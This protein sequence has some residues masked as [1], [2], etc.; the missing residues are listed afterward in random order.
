MSLPRCLDYVARRST[1]TLTAGDD[2]RAGCSRNPPRTSPGARLLTESPRTAP[3]H[4]EAYEGLL[5]PARLQRIRVPLLTSHG[6]FELLAARLGV[7]VARSVADECHRISGGSP[8]LVQALAD[9]QLAEG[10]ARDDRPVLGEAFRDAVLSCLYRCE[11][12]LLR[13]ARALAVSG[14][15]LRGGLSARLVEGHGAAVL[16]SIDV[17]TSGGLVVD[18]RLRHPAVGQA[19]LDGM[20]AE[21]RVRLHRQ[22][23]GLLH[24]D[25]APAGEVARH[26]VQAGTPVE[27]WMTQALVEGGE[28]ALRDGDVHTSLRYLRQANRECPDDGARTRVR[29]ALVRAEWQLD[30]Q[31]V[32]PHLPGLVDAVRSGHLGAHQ[33]A[34]PV[35]YLLWHGLVDTAVELVK[36]LRE[37]HETGDTQSVTDLFVT[38]GWLTMLYPG[39]RADSPAPPLPTHDPPALSRI[40]QQLQGANML[41]AVLERGDSAAVDD[42]EQALHAAGPDLDTSCWTAVCVLQAMIYAD[43]LDMAEHWRTR[44]RDAAATHRHPTPSAVLD[45]LAAVIALRRGDLSGAR[46]LADGALARLPAR[47]WGVAI[48]LPLAVRLR[49]L[50]S[51]GELDTAAECLRVPVPAA[52]FETRL[53]LHYLHARGGYALAADNPAAALADFQLC[54]RLM[55]QW[56]LDL[57]ALVPWRTD[58]ARALLRQG[59]RQ[60]AEILVRE[61]LARLRPGHLRQRGAALRVLAT[62]TDPPDRLEHL[63]ASVHALQQSDD[64]LELAHSLTDLGHA[65]QVLGDHRQARGAAR[66]ARTLAEEC[67]LPLPGQD[68]PS[69]GRATARPRGTPGPVDGLSD[70]ESRVAILAAQ[71]HT[72]REIADKLFLTVS[73]IEQRLT[74]VYRKLAVNSRSELAARLRPPHPGAIAAGRGAAVTDDA[75]RRRVAGSG[76]P[77]TPGGPGS[78]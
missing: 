51:L 18:G 72:N 41:G 78:H 43:R 17:N 11:H 31:A 76:H 10:A 62:V 65:H 26:V 73:T 8:L 34:R 35:H 4:P 70:A 16:E 47:G 67:G 27:P 54:G 75:G 33:A 56:R 3:W 36:L 74:R 64:R 20:T 63:R 42:A 53:G 24:R 19:V 7:P 23:A 1:T 9:D 14:Q 12:L 59:N 22:A 60:Q 13:A 71:G 50:T 69:A 61:E 55:A 77:Q 21:E 48:G 30:P 25:G 58:A 2:R 40:R 38:N 39:A 68:P 49:A 28:Q 57:P 37:R 32:L 29:S 46:R 52:L 45:A 6:T 44:L 66:A 15:S 5:Q